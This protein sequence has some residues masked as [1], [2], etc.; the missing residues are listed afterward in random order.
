M[1]FKDFLIETYGKSDQGQFCPRYIIWSMLVRVHKVLPH[2]KYQSSGRSRSVS[3]K[4]NKSNSVPFGCYSYQSYFLKWLYCN[5]LSTA[6]CVLC[7]WLNCH[8]SDLEGRVYGSVCLAAEIVVFTMYV[9]RRRYWKYVK[10]SMFIFIFLFVDWYFPLTTCR[11]L[12][13][14]FNWLLIGVDMYRNAWN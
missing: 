8:N 10:V 1:L 2:S 14:I 7:G 13:V 12:L 11:L 5:K 6:W 4:K 3:E 9:H